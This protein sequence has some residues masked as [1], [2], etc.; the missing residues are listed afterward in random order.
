MQA[1]EEEFRSIVETTREW[2][3][4]ID[5]RARV[6][7]SNPAVERILGYR[8]EELIGKDALLFMHEEDR[9]EI[10]EVLPKLVS[11]KKGW[12]EL[13]LRWRHKNGTYRYL[14]SNAVP[15]LNG[16]G[17]LLGY[18][19]AD[20]DITE[21]KEVEAKLR[22]SEAELRALFE[23]MDDVILVLDSEGRY[24]SIAP[25]KP[26]LL[27][28]PPERLVS[29][30][31]HEV[32][33]AEQADMFLDCVRRALETRQPVNIEYSLQ[34]DGEEVWFAGTVSPMLE[35]SVVWVARDVTERKRAE[36]ELSRSE[37]RLA[38]AQRIAHLGN[39]EWDVRTGE[40]FWSDEVYRIYGHAPKAFV[41][42]FDKLMEAIHPDDRELL[43]E[44]IGGALCKGKPYDFEHR[45]VRPD[46]EVRVV[47][48]RAEVVFDDEGM[49]VRMVGT[50]HDVTERKALEERLEHQALHDP[51]T[52]LPNRTLFVD[53]LGHALTRLGRRGGKAA[54]LFLD[55]D[56]FKFV[57][58]SLGHEAGDE[59]LAAVSGRLRACLRP[60][61]TAARLGGDEFAVLL[62]NVAGVDDAA[63]VA[64]RI[65]GE[66][67]E[68][69]VVRGHEVFATPSIGIAFGG[70][71]QD[72]P[73]NLLRDADVAMYR[74]KEE[75]KARH[76]V[77]E[78]AMESQIVERLRL[79]ND[80]RR[81]L[82]RDELR[83]YYQPVVHLE[84]E[85]VMGMEALVRWEHPERGLVIPDEFIPLA[86]EIG[87]IVPIG[88]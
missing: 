77:F 22:S 75:G 71:D 37:A 2:I 49:P 76:L 10:E 67:R 78:E 86:E 68:P 42:T 51:L 47:H 27:Y 60:E 58:D 6:T 64:E 81:A 36:E 11:K 44:A 30:T 7:Y 45:V 52:D 39:W 28:K 4:T 29:K 66:L 54:V 40:I 14:E 50:V 87:L 25:T 65:T 69:F 74:A 3:W 35:D 5:R 12:S 41:P 88:R 72:R 80:L 62:E 26:S 56:N 82:E 20:R 13:V 34:I 18:R 57:N 15:I 84:T 63:Q 53:R 59:L 23:A 16:G 1:S 24:L 33:P 21:R 17:E 83:V 55:L 19:G 46:G 70:S 38:G 48:R 8:P 61:D 73:E 31:L 32:F 85:Q 79:E 9:I 43:R